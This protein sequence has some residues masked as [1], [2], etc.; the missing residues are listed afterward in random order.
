MADLA[1]DPCGLA[2]D[3]RGWLPWAVIPAGPGWYVGLYSCGRGHVW[4]CG[5]GMV[6]DPGDP[7]LRQLKV[8][9]HRIVP[10]DDYLAE[11]GGCDLLAPVRIVLIDW[12]PVRGTPLTRPTKRTRRSNPWRPND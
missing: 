12:T 1:Y 10:G 2:A 6:A 8:S 7:G 11:H 4:T 5:Y 3:S 9:P